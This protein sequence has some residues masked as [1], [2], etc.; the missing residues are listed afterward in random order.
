MI[1]CG[2]CDTLYELVK[3]ACKCPC[4]GAENYPEEQDDAVYTCCQVCGIKL[5]AHDEIVGMCNRCANE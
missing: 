5:G 2:D 1:K 4:C 3:D